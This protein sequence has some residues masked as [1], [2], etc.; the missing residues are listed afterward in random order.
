MFCR[1]LYETNQNKRAFAQIKVLNTIDLNND[2][3]KAIIYDLSIDVSFMMGE[4]EQV[5]KFY[6]LLSQNENSYLFSSKMNIL[7]LKCLVANAT[8]NFEET[9]EEFEKVKKVI[10]ID[11]N[12]IKNLY[13]YYLAIAYYKNNIYDKCLVILKEHLDFAPSLAMYA[14]FV[15]KIGT[16]SEKASFLAFVKN[17]K[18]SKFECLYEEFCTYVSLSI[19][20]ENSYQLY[21]FIKQKVLTHNSLFYD[22]IIKELALK[23]LITMGLSSSKYKETLRFIEDNQ[24]KS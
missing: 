7:K 22:A 3:M 2:F 15:K 10:N 5:V 20:N 21:N 24:V 1:Y 18:F 6:Y 17:K 9:L 8:F 23:E 13:Y 11:D 4:Y 12:N 16:N 14:Y 19:R